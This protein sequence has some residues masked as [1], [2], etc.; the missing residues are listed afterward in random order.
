VWLGLRQTTKEVFA[1]KQMQKARI[2]KTGQQRNVCNEKKLLAATDH[3]FVRCACDGAQSSGVF[4][5]LPVLP[6]L[7]TGLVVQ[8]ILKLH[9]AFKDK[10]C[11]YLVLEFLQ[12]GDMFGHLYKQGGKFDTPTSVFYAAIVLTVFEHLHNQYVP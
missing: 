7:T 2:V 4:P 1:L 11:L 10:D 3:P 12:G 6:V 8:Q 9:N 5:Q